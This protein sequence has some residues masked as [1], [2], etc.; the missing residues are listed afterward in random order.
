[1]ANIADVEFWRGSY[2]FI[3]LDPY[4]LH[5]DDLEPVVRA[6]LESCRPCGKVIFYT[7]SDVLRVLMLINL[8]RLR[9]I[10]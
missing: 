8:L 5:P 9:W 10:G 3:F 6:A 1:M 7:Y 2:D 4:D